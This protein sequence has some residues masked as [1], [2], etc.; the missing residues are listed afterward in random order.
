MLQDQLMLQ[1]GQPQRISPMEIT[2]GKRVNE[3]S[4][5]GDKSENQLPSP[6]CLSIYFNFIAGNICAGLFHQTSID[7]IQVN[8]CICML[9]QKPGVR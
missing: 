1:D 9:P 8:R 6:V 5:Y 2:R 3:E 4:S 7:G